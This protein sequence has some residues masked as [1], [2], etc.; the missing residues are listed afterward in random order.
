MVYDRAALTRPFWVRE[1]VAGG[2]SVSSFMFIT[3]YKEAVGQ[4]L[5]KLNYFQIAKK[6]RQDM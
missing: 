3:E 4:K 1:T 5:S 2:L 6:R